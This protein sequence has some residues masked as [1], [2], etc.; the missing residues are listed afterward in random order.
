[1]VQLSLIDDRPEVTL[2]S[3]VETLR[4]CGAR[5]IGD[6]SHAAEA[7][8]ITLRRFALLPNCR[9][10]CAEVRRVDA[11]YNAV[12]RRRVLMSRDASVAGARRRLVAASIEADLVAAGWSVRRARAE[13][14]RA[15]GVTVPSPASEVA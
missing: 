1:M 4:S 2:S 9:L 13:A 3:R 8:R 11:Y 6:G 10:T 14:S 15:V 7:A 12:L 5:S